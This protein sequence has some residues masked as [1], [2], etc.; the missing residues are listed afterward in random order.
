MKMIDKDLR[1]K[2]S[3][4][5]EIYPGIY[6]YKDFYNE[7][8]LIEECLNSFSELEWSSHG[9][10]YEND[11]KDSFW[12]DKLSPDMID[13]KFHDSIINFV[14][15]EYW[16]LSHGN[17]M[18]LRPEEGCP[19]YNNNLPKEFEYIMAYYAGDFTG[20]SLSFLDYDFDYQPE[21]NDLIIFKPTSFDISPVLSGTR[22][23][24]LDY[25]LKHPGYIIV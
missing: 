20:G 22:Y 6:L 15:P 24:Y 23:S 21:R 3:P 13:R 19:V 25:V 12:N 4:A 5:N 14:S 17:F 11:H 10:Y 9:N 8:N 1:F 16:I 2:S 7:V 18:R